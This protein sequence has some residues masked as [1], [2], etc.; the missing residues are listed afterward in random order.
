MIAKPIQ[1]VLRRFVVGSVAALLLTFLAYR[2][3]FNLSAA[4]SLH[5]CPLPASTISLPNLCSSS[6]SLIRTIG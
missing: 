5:L 4:T 6:T 3:H 2:L 1:V